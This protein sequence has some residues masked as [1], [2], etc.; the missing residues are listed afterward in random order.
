M[1]DALGDHKGSVSIIHVGRI[2][3]NFCSVD[4]VVVNAEE[5]DAYD[6]VTRMDST[7]TK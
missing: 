7:C 5:E 4:D 6:I 1:I 2:F 3:I